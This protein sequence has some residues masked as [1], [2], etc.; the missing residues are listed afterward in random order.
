[1]ITTLWLGGPDGP[2]IAGHTIGPIWFLIKIL[3]ILYVF[4]WIRATLPRMR[5][6]QLME[7]AW[8]RMIPLAL[9]MLMIDAG[10]Q[11]SRAWGLV[12]VAG[13]LVGGLLL[14]RAVSVGGDAARLEAKRDRMLGLTPQ[15]SGR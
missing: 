2:A 10:F 5:Y 12:A 7:L 13:S 8:K 14:F 3:I 11:V 15:E 4:V 1:M 9:A 6:D